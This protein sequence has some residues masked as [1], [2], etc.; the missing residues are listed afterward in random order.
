MANRSLPFPPHSWWPS[1]S[2][3][4]SPLCTRTPYAFLRPLGFAH[5]IIFLPSLFFFFLRYIVSV[6]RKPFPRAR[7][8]PAPSSPL[9]VHRPFRVAI[10]DGRRGGSRFSLEGQIVVMNFLTRTGPRI[11]P[12]PVLYEVPANLSSWRIVPF[13]PFVFSREW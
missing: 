11:E 2:A 4:R 10:V 3:T 5:Y 9:R 1:K 12:S 13:S 7:R 6:V 8:G